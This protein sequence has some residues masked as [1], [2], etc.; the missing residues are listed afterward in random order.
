MKEYGKA[1]SFEHRLPV[2]LTTLAVMLLLAFM[3]GRIRLVPH[4]GICVMAVIVL[5]PMVLVGIASD[6]KRWLRIEHVVT[7]LICVLG[8]VMNAI[9]LIGL[10]RA[11]L[12]RP[13]AIT[14]L[15]LLS[16]SIGVW[17]ANVLVFSLLY[18]QIDRGGPQARF[19]TTAKKSDWH[20]PAQDFSGEV[21]A[22]WRPRF[23][24]YLFLGFST[25]T[26]FS[27]TEAIPL[28]PR[29]KI[30]IMIQSLIS[31]ITLVV[32]GARAINILGS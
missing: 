19:D 8:G 25:S 23:I 15:Q 32:V 5:L 7:V 18:W 12:Q 11:M 27:M 13:I 30:L 24:D 16:S 10:V 4:W 20:F 6:K 29:A 3:P 9:N 21:P 22:D 31:L 2:V 14:G 26:A 1:F 28:T 17:V